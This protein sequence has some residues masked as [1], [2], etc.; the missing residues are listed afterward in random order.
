MKAPF[1]GTTRWMAPELLSGDEADSNNIK[2]SDV[3]SFG[4]VLW[5]INTRQLPYAN[6]TDPQVIALKQQGKHPSLDEHMPMASLIRFCW[7]KKDNRPTMP[8]SVGDLENDKD[9]RFNR[10]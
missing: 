1:G 10:Q 6:K 5:E 9:L 8:Q 7:Q 4:V 2:A 3:Y